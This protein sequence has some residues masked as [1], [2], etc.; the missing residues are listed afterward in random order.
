MLYRKISQTIDSYLKSD[1]EKI[2]VIDGARQIGKS[3][4]IREESKKFYPHY[5]EIN[6]KNDFDG[7]KL[8]EKTTTTEAFY[9][10]ASALYG[11]DMDSYDNTII[12]LDE[13]QVYPHLLSM[14]K[15]LK[16]EKR[17][18]FIV[19]GSLLGVTM[20]HVF[21]PMGAINE[22]PMHQL[23]FEEFLIASGVGE[24]ALAHLKARFAERKPLSEGLHETFMNYFR[25]YLISGGLPDAV[26]ALLL[27]KN[28]AKVRKVQADTRRYYIDDA[29]R[30]DE[31]HSL[32]IRRI[33]EL[34]PSFIDNKISRLTFSS[35]GGGARGNRFADYEDEYDYLIF[36]GIVNGSRAISEPKFPLVQ[37]VSKS[38]IK[39]YLNDVGLLSDIL[40]QNNVAPLLDSSLDANLGPLYE[41]FA[42]GEL[43]AHGHE[44]YY[45]DRRKEGDVDFLV[46]NYA[47]SCPLPIEI[48][49]GRG[50]LNYSA[51]PKMLA[52]EN[53]HIK[54]GCL[55]SNNREVALDGKI[56]KM[57]IYMMMFI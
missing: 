55:F 22:V 54:Y 28:V 16:E 50:S 37:S 45:F 38:L 17:Y 47:D 27:D 32:K 31:A 34:I 48:K 35:I 6:L 29:S 19:S 4:I 44:L 51:L 12:F 56:L 30:Y 5:V 49:S 11:T 8:F 52:C 42:A 7:P 33:Y 20:K 41:T 2:M 10:Q 9:L 1:D 26:N 36:S 15:P 40:F 13:I 39:L 21:I 24:A 43:S 53:Y 18:R 23:D 14:L 57:P 46:N 3:Y 25:Q